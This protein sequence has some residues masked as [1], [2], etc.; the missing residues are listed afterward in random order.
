MEE[1]DTRYEEKLKNTEIK[2]FTDQ[3]TLAISYV[4]PAANINPSQIQEMKSTETMPRFP[5]WPHTTQ[6]VGTS[7]SHHHA[8]NGKGF[9][10]LLSIQI[11][12][13]IFAKHFI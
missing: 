5:Q 1:T 9:E 8:T 3:T 2:K 10:F 12:G 6:Q 7:S 11:M 4:P 13:H